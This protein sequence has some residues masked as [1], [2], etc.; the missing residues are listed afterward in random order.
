MEPTRCHASCAV[1]AE[2]AVLLRGRPGSGKSEL[3]LRLVAEAGAG[4]LADDQV[5]LRRDGDRLI[6]CAPAALGGVVEA[7]GIGL[8]R[9]TPTGPT[10]VA[11]LA[12]LTA[13]PQ[14]LPEPAE[15][16]LLGCRLRRVE[17][18]PRAPS[19]VAKLQLALGGR[20]AAIL[21]ADW[22]PRAPADWGGDGEDT[23]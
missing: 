8:L 19:A 20:G 14:R 11:L 13:R 23:R 9:L 1:L 15:E 17:V 3:L 21:P 18:D 22:H 4:L 2:R 12:D 10:A 16:T 6:A 7:R 5:L